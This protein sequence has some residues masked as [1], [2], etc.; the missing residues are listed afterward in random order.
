MLA[1]GNL[2]LDLRLAHPARTQRSQAAELAHALAVAAADEGL[3]SLSL[4]DRALAQI[5]GDEVMH[6]PKLLAHAAAW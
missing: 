1:V 5:T 2:A 3:D 6:G 4:E